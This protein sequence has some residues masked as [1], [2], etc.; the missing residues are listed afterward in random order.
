[1][2]GSKKIM[3]GKKSEN[4]AKTDKIL[5]GYNSKLADLKK[6]RDMIVSDFVGFLREKKL[7][8][9]KKSLDK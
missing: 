4:N 7:E 1:M 2:N 5:E 6:E 3:D 8:E 9:V